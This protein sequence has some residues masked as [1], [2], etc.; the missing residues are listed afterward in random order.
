MALTL[1][2]QIVKA[3]VE[4][5]AQIANLLSCSPIHSLLLQSPCCLVLRKN[6]EHSFL[7]FRSPELNSMGK[8]HLEYRKHILYSEED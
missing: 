3:L 8:I 4:R 1:R 5:F 2:S 6:P 7:F